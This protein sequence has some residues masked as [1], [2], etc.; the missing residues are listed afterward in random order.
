MKIFRIV[1]LILLLVLPSISHAAD[2][3]KWVDKDG[4]VNFS[5]DLSKVPPEYRDQIKTEEVT[6]S[7]QPQ[8]STP[9]P[10]SVQKTEEVRDSQKTQTSTPQQAETSTPAP[11]SDQDQVTEEGIRDFRGR[12]EDYRRERIR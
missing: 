3:Y 6:D 10:A 11:A 8:T 5:D 2:I 12:P 4:A 1:M 7:Q 9:A